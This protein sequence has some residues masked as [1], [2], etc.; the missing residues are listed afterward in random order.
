[1]TNILIF[2]Y[3]SSGEETLKESEGAGFSFSS[4]EVHDDESVFDHDYE[5]KDP[6][7]AA[8]GKVE[9][10]LR[11]KISSVFLYQA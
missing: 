1:M 9:S 6:K 10:I 5:G 2:N 8:V 11:E 7:D 4:T 3:F